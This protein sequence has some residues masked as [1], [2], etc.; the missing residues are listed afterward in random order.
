MKILLS[1]GYN[2]SEILSGPEKVLKRLYQNLHSQQVLLIDYFR[3]GKKY[4][5]AKKFFGKEIIDQGK[6]KSVLRLGL[7]RI[8]YT[9]LN[10]GPEIIHIVTFERFT[11]LAVLFALLKKTK[12]VYTVNGIV[13]YE[14]KLRR[15]AGLILR[16][17]DFIYE[18]LLFRY[19]DKLFF[20]SEQS[21]GIADDC[22]SF[23]HKKVEIAFNGIDEVY[24][25][26][27]IKSEKK[28]WLDI[29]CIGDN[30]RVEKGI[31]SL[32]DFL[33]STSLRYKLHII[34][35]PDLTTAQSNIHYY[36]KM[37]TDSYAKFLNDKDVFI[38]ASVYEPFSIAAAEAMA[39]GL[40]VIVSKQT[41]MNRYINNGINGFIYDVDNKSEL[42][43]LL[44]KIQQNRSEYISIQNEAK[45]VYSLLSWQNAAENY[46]NNYKKILS[47][48]K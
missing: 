23:D 39:A 36:N 22:Y 12:I 5:I 47:G 2:E 14:H 44:I 20:L 3:D 31:A 41:G 33:N 27:K 40:I 16:L 38:S 24:S 46:L 11:I 45:K 19:S 4:S 21:L 48:V 25:V 42:K 26:N 17:K 9:M 37:D 10:F 7:F 32:I 28:D 34:G 35:K 30:T 1:G 6:D 8:I 15:N 43:D 18:T 29:V 13:K